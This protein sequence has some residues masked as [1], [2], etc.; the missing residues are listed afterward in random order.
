MSI[1][2]KSFFLGILFTL[3]LLAIGVFSFY[4]GKASNDKAPEKDTLETG[5]I[6]EATPTPFL[7][8]ETLKDKIIIAF[9]VNKFEQ[10]IDYLYDPVILQ[11]EN[12][13]CCGYQTPKDVIDKLDLLKESEGVW[14]FEQENETLKSLAASHP[15]NYSDSFI[16]ITDDFYSVS[17][18]FNSDGFIDKISISTSYNDLLEK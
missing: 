16:G 5:F 12:T 15:E 4:M 17:F 8:T 2:I 3:M 6:I 14:D 18:Q 13:N 10:L 1:K 7:D 9:Y 11:I